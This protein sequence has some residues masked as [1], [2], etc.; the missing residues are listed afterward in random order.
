MI[1]RAPETKHACPP[2]HAQPPREFL[3]CRRNPH[4]PGCPPGT[5]TFGGR[6]TMLGAGG[7]PHDEPP[8]ATVR[9]GRRQRVG[10]ARVTDAQGGSDAPGQP[11]ADLP[12]SRRRVQGSFPTALTLV[13]RH[14]L[15]LRPGWGLVASV[16]TSL[17]MMM[18]ASLCLT[19]DWPPSLTSDRCPVRE[20][21]RASYPFPFSRSPSY[22]DYHLNCPGNG[23]IFSNPPIPKNFCPSCSLGSGN[24]TITLLVLLMSTDSYMIKP[25]SSL[26]CYRRNGSPHRPPSTKG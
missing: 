20:W 2:G 19:C 17:P 26:V 1:G 10:G 16:L 22:S 15:W 25:R 5:Y 14:A 3:A 23:K 24:Q 21:I 8:R 6:G 13:K 9:R 4:H 12:I 7:L 11:R 18:A